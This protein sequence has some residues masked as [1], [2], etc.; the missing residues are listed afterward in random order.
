MISPADILNGKILLVDDMKANVVLL[1]KILR[2]AGYASVASTTD[3]RAV[4]ELH[5]A[6][7]YDLILLDLSMPGMDGYQ[8]MD[9]LKDIEAGGYLP[10]LV[11]TAQP[12]QKLRALNAGARDFVSKPFDVAEVLVR[13]HNMIEVRLLHLEMKKLYEQV[14]AEQRVSDRLLNNVLPRT[15]IERL[16]VRPEAMAESFTELIADRFSEVTVLFADIVGFTKFSERVSPEDLVNILNDLFTCF[17]N[18]ADARGLE[19]I[20]TIG[21]CYMAAAGIPVAAPDHA[22]RAA[23]MALDMIEAL[24]RFN[25]RRGVS[26]DMRIGIGSGE[27]VAGV[28]G[29]RKFRYD[30]WGDVVNTASRMESHGVPGR[31][32]LTDA[33][34]R[35][36]SEAFELEERGAIE[37]RGKGEMHTW[38][39][40][41][42]TAAVMA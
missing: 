27:V 15:I 31:I 33:T 7:R 8:V 40:K 17:D 22:T 32:Q 42:R 24:K 10:V 37:V 2:G 29:K 18:I 4:Q 20:K 34:R 25:L 16:K 38:F 26:L 21:D 9:G 19:Q 39:L 36:L 14:V 35:L 6:N 13:V 1:D 23:H 5:R 28:I 12:E 11:L 41:S 3:P 30:V